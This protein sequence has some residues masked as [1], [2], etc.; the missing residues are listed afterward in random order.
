M[1]R[2]LLVVLILALPALT[3]TRHWLCQETL[4]GRVTEVLSGD[5]LVIGSRLVRLEQVAVAGDGALAAEAREA[6]RRVGA[7]ESVRCVGC[8]R[9]KSAAL[10]GWC[11]LRDG[12]R[13]G[14]LLVEAGVARDCPAASGGVYASLEHERTQ[15]IAL[16]ERCRPWIRRGARP[17][18]R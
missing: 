1:P 7:G 11:E 16:P 15:A 9:S 10:V 12:T 17:P 18:L 8:A 14:R 13:F 5:R 2:W 3:L 4:E 6:L